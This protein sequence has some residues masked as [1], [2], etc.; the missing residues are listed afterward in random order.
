M[1]NFA[2]QLQQQ[3]AVKNTPFWLFT[4][5]LLCAVFIAVIQSQSRNYFDDAYMFVRYADHLLQGF[6]HSWNIGE[7]AIYGSTSIF[8]VLQ[9]AVIRALGFFNATETVVL[10]SS[11]QAFG[12]W[13]RWRC[14][15]KP[16]AACCA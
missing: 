4:A 6:G 9:V 5:L 11:F 7:I 13:P 15:Q 10:L 1:P 12:R 16:A 14:W 3:K 8:Y 2:E